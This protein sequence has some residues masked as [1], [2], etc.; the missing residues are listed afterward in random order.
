MWFSGLSARLWTKALPFRFPVRAHAWFRARFPVR[1][2]WEAATHWCLCPS[3]SPFL[4]LSLKIQIKKPSELE[5]FPGF[6]HF[7]QVFTTI[8]SRPNSKAAVKT[9]DP[10]W[11]CQARNGAASWGSQVQLSPSL[12]AWNQEDPVNH[13]ETE[14]LGNSPSHPWLMAGFTE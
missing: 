5:N 12:A 11:T 7:P 10:T 14:P 2:A 1:G 3:L 8:F 4:S 9:P 6:Y 13:C